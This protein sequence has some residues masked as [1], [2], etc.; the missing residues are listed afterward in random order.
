M[1]VTKNSRRGIIWLVAGDAAALALTTLIGFA[2]HGE[3]QPA[4]LPRTLSTFLPLLAGWFL[5]SPWLGL[6]DLALAAQ[7][8]RLWRPPLAMLLG[9]PLAG[10]LRGVLLGAEVVPLFVLTLGVSAA[11]FLLLWRGLYCFISPKR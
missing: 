1:A 6:F 7:G 5:I 8:R 9:A 10:V 4:L 3:L 11:F 2:A